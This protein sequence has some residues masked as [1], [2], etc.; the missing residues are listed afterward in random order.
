MSAT[1]IAVAVAADTVGRAAHPALAVV[2]SLSPAPH[3]PCHSQYKVDVLAFQLILRLF[4]AENVASPSAE[5]RVKRRRHTAAAQ[6]LAAA[7]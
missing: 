4:P 3:T 5:I 1:T 6:R 2:M 7:S